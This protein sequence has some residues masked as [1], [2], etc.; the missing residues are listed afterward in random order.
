MRSLAS[1]SSGRPLRDGQAIRLR[2]LRPAIACSASSAGPRAFPRSARS[3]STREWH[4]THL[5]GYRTTAAQ[6]RGDAAALTPFV[7]MDTF[8]RLPATRFRTGC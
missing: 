8:F 3:C 1:R 5:Q 6:R 7:L 4:R 2:C